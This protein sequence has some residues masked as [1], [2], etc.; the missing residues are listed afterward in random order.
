MVGYGNGCLIHKLSYIKFD[1]IISGVK[2]AS[3]NNLQIHKSLHLEEE[4]DTPDNCELFYSGRITGFSNFANRPDYKQLEE[5]T[6]RFGNWMC[7]RPQVRGD[8]YSVGSQWLRLALFKGPKRVGVSPH[9]RTETDPVSDMSCFSFNYLESEN[10]VILCIIHHRQNPIQSTVLL[11]RPKKILGPCLQTD[12]D[13][14]S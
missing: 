3:S 6:R 12:H 14:L 10:S 1:A 4:A 11:S 8:T 9:L 2:T 5:K 7:F 13:L